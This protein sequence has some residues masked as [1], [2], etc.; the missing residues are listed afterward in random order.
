MLLQI[1]FLLQLL[2]VYV[3]AKMV[4]QTWKLVSRSF[5]VLYCS[6]LDQYIIVMQHLNVSKR[7]CF[8]KL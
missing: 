1:V 4:Q 3:S 7:V 6:Y 2:Q 8:S 5:M